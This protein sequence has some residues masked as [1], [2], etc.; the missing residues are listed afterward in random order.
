MDNLIEQLETEISF[1]D[2]AHTVR[3]LQGILIN[4]KENHREVRDK[5]SKCI[6]ELAITET[7]EDS[8][9][10]QGKRIGIQSVAR[11]TG[12]NL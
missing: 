8:E 7:L 2:D 4:L 12:V 9:Y 1:C 3:N 6:R 5:Y 10:W 11:L